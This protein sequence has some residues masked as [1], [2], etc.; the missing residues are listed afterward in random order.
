MCLWRVDVNCYLLLCRKLLHRVL[1]QGK[2]CKEFLAEA[3][4]SYH[5]QWVKWNTFPPVFVDMSPLRGKMK[6]KDAFLAKHVH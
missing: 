1:W 5:F 3:K 2:L 6:L 4:Y